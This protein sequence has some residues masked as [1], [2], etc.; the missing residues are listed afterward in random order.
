MNSTKVP[1]CRPGIRAPETLL[2]ELARTPAC[3]H[4]HRRR[5]ERKQP[6]T[7]PAS[8]W[9]SVRGTSETGSDYSTVFTV[10]LSIDWVDRAGHSRETQF[11]GRQTDLLTSQPTNSIPSSQNSNPSEIQTIKFDEITDASASRL[12]LFSV[13]GEYSFRALEFIESKSAKFRSLEPWV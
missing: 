8:L 10:H 11:T 2:P 12:N 1:S 6:D 9:T 13:V 5:E 3:T 7:K 4:P